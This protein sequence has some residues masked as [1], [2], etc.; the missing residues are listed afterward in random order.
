MESVQSQ[1]GEH[2]AAYALTVSADYVPAPLM[3]QIH[4]YD[5]WVCVMNMLNEFDLNLLISFQALIEERSI[6]RAGRRLSR[7]QPAMSRIFDRLQDMFGDVL[8]VRTARGYE[9]THRALD[10]YAELK[11]LLPR[12]ETLLRPGEFKVSEVTGVFRIA[13]TDYAALVVL[14]GLT[15]ALVKTAPLL[16]VEV[17]P[18]D[19]AL[20]KLGANTLDLAFQSTEGPQPFHSESVFEDKIVC[21][22]RRGH[23]LCESRI[24][25]DT[26]LHWR[27]VAGGGMPGLVQRNLDRLG[28][29]PKVQLRVPF[30][31]LG[32]VIERTDMIATV[33]HR[34]AKRIAGM[35]NTKVIPAP[36]EF[37][38][39]TYLQ[40]WHP[41]YDSDPIHKWLRDLIKHIAA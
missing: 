35:S 1:D 10:I 11:Q 31:V 7:T 25:L 2:R 14:P 19:N 28:A 34:M 21:L 41:R 40:V 30:S 16:R 17:S 32:P 22:V 38:R 33:P 37:D 3:K 12:I 15:K 27:H 23:P 29:K 39:F 9:P 18:I 24:T 5:V 36:K 4:Y 26:Y 13:A 8:L 20:E 6:T